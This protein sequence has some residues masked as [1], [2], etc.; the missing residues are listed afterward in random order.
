MSSKHLRGSQ[1][2][3][4]KLVQHNLSRSESGLDTDFADLQTFY[5]GMGSLCNLKNAPEV[6]L[7][8]DHDHR[9]V[10]LLSQVNS[11]ASGP[12][13]I[14]IEK[15][16]TQSGM[17]IQDI[18]GFRK[19]T[20]LLDPIRW[21]QGKYSFPKHTILPWHQESWEATY[22][23]LQDPMNQAYVEALAA[24]AFSR[25]READLTPH[26]HFFYGSICGKANTYRFNIT[27]SY[28]SL[29]HRRWFWSGQEKNMFKIS[30]DDT[31]PDEIKQAIMEQ[32]ENLTDDTD[33]EEESEEEI[34]E[35]KDL[36]CKLD[37]DKGSLHSAS[38]S[39]FQSA[40][41]EEENED[42]EEYSDDDD[43]LE[44][45]AEIKDFPI[46]MIFTEVSKGTMDDL[47][48]DEDEVGAKRGTQKWDAIWKA[49]IFQVIAALCI[50]Q[51]VFGFTHNDLHSNNVVWSPT[52]EKYVFYK[53]KDGTIYRVPTYGKIFRIIDFGRSI[54]KLNDH[55][56]FSDDFRPGNDAA[57]QYNFGEILD[58]EEEEVH[59]NPSF[60]LCRF[61]VSI[62]EALFPS[63]PP[64]RKGGKIL[65]EE[66][67][68][69]VKETQSDLYNLLWTWLVC[70]D[71]HNVLMDGD[72]QERYPD[73][74]L[75]KVISSQVH[76]A[77][78]SEQIRK[79][80]FDNF[81]VEASQ[82]KEHKVYPLFC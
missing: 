81:I 20:H 61:T 41:S 21:L 4:P 54:F 82:V 71:G 22:V 18:S 67:D 72:G 30:F 33:S 77:I 35:L 16:N 64:P 73:F 32:P 79:S 69:V 74:E 5:P 65:S 1:I 15:N 56:F 52:T 29:R 12:V 38:G 34:E 19:I 10:K 46:M 26:Y 25:L 9:F 24:Y 68:F 59:P 78:P 62:F 8:F 47:L 66:P 50:G 58:E 11:K 76:G 60:D 75:Y 13:S 57:E 7:W 80:F 70:D 6:D 31:I 40:G 37:D 14:R 36:H 23:K 63:N 17:E 27:D 3:K 49:W 39:D 2:P 28:L 55:L 53:L 48:D 51:S 44:I 43:G 42:S 45:F